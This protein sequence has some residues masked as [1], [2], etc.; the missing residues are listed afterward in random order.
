MSLCSF[1]SL[2]SEGK[3][4]K[5]EL[6]PVCQCLLSW[7]GGPNLDI[8]LQS[9]KWWE[10]VLIIPVVLLGM[11]LLVQPRMLFPFA[12]QDSLLAHAQLAIY[13]QLQ[14]SLSKAAPK[15]VRSQ[16]VSLQTLFLPSCSTWHLF[17]LNFIR[18]LLDNSFCL[19]RPPW[20]AILPSSVWI[21]PQA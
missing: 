5:V 17:I 20:M 11:L 8:W 13:K 14:V 10:K 7:A 2:S 9:H 12:L 18:F 1:L 4:P 19:S 15:L 16:P 6:T 21:G 3:C